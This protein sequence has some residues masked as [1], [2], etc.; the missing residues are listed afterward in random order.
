[1]DQ[2]HFGNLRK[3]PQEHDSELH[4]LQLADLAFVVSSLP[5][6]GVPLK[7]YAWV[8]QIAVGDQRA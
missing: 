5:D 6:D 1:M 3:T 4:F 7:R 2:I 8:K